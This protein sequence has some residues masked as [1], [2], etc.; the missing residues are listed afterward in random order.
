M[1]SSSPLVQ[2][3]VSTISLTIYK[4]SD[5]GD[6]NSV[7]PVSGHTDVSLSAASVIFDTPQAD[8]LWGDTDTTGYNFRHTIDVSQNDA[9][10]EHDA[11]YYAEYTIMPVT[12]Q[13]IKL[14]F[15]IA[16]D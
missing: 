6:L 7:V 14:P 5:S 8:D 15:V 4:L 2:A 12:G 11:Y 16:C 9:F 3:D 13:V 1:E 10:D